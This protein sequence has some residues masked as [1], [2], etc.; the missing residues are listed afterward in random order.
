MVPCCVF[1]ALFLLNITHFSPFIHQ[2]LG[3]EVSIIFLPGEI[4]LWRRL[5]PHIGDPNV[6]N[7]IQQQ[8]PPTIRTS[9]YSVWGVNCWGSV[10]KEGITI[11]AARR[12]CSPT[13][14][15]KINI[16][17]TFMRLGEICRQLCL[18]LFR[19]AL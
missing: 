5:T 4:F 3:S 18:A 2:Q 19:S 17:F 8:Q 1:F 16:N 9:T 11:L 10:I 6:L 12:F 14:G 15:A 13:R 7:S